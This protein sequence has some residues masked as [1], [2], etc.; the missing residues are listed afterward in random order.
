MPKIEDYEGCEIWLEGGYHVA[1]DK[2]GRRI[3]SPSTGI[4]AARRRIRAH[5]RKKLR[6]TC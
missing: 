2:S 4:G 1:Y 6:R 5:V 3:G